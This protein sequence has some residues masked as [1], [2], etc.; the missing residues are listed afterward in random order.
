MN[1]QR[2]I[3]KIKLP[4]EIRDKV[5]PFSDDFWENLDEKYYEY[6]LT[7]YYEFIVKQSCN[8]KKPKKFTEKIQ[9]LKLYDSTPIKTKLTDKVLVRDWVKEKIGEEYLKEVFCVADKFDDINFESLPNSF[10][11]K[12]NHASGYYY[13]IKDKAKFLKV[14][15]LFNLIKQNLEKKLNINFY[16]QAGL[17]LQYKNIIPKLLIEEN[18]FPNEDEFPIEYQI[19]CFNGVPKIYQK[20][21]CTKFPT[22]TIYNQDYSIAQF[23]FDSRYR[24]IDE[25]APESLK[26]A[27]ELSKKLSQDFKL[28]RVDW[29]YAKEKLYFNEMTFTPYSGFYMFENQ[30]WDY[31]IGKL[32]KL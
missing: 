23:S 5:P 13:K 28:V 24:C 10:F 32:L 30:K 27:V 21:N 19:F 1:I 2:L 15:K 31:E 12:T 4:K 25:E 17:E 20:F 18:L 6:F 7:L 14:E 29:L 26:K 8:L 16:T 22:T 3:E 9:W 11:I